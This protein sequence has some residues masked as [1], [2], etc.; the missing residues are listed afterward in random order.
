MI[1]SSCIVLLYLSNDR[2]ILNADHTFLYYQIFVISSK[3]RWQTWSLSHT[4]VNEV[5]ISETAE[6]AAFNCETCG[7]RLK[8]KKTLRQHKQLKHPNQ[9]NPLPPIK[10]SV[11]LQ[12]IEAKKFKIHM[13]ERHPGEAIEEKCDL[14]DQLFKTVYNLKRH[15]DNVHNINKR[16]ECIICGKFRS[17]RSDKM[18]EQMQLH[19]Q[20]QHRCESC[21]FASNRQR[22]LLAHR[23]K[24]KPKHF[25]CRLCG[26]KSTSKTALRQHKMRDHG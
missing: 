6:E 17:Q 24:C 22:E 3:E 13:K 2:T 15:K 14:C 5:E 18:R 16:F 25:S 9:D 8:S 4:I 23:S 11:C 21:S 7:K 20:Q 19:Q 26:K 1:L 10:C 12:I